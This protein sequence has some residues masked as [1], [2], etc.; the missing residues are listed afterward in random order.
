MTGIYYSIEG[1]RVAHILVVDDDPSVVKFLQRGLGFEGLEV[2]GCYAGEEALLGVQER[3]PDLVI[4]DWML[5]G[6]QGN[7]VLLCLQKSHPSLP[8]LILSGTDTSFEQAKMVWSGANAVLVK[9]VDFKVLLG[10]IL[11]LIQNEKV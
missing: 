5:P 2:S 10:H 11:A 8:V 9:P 1:V 3:V 6:M 4:L 7:D